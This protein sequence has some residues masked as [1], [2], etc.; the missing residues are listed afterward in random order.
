MAKLLEQINNT[1]RK[2][3][4]IKDLGHVVTGKTPS[5]NNPEDWGDEIDFITPTDFSGDGKYLSQ[6]KRKISTEGKSRYRN[7]II[8]PKSVVVTCIGSDMGKVV[9]SQET[10]LTNQQIN[11]II[12]DENSF[13]VD[14]AYYVLKAMYSTLRSIAEEG[15]ST[16]PIIT[17][18]VFEKIDFEAPDLPTQ[19]KI[20]SILSAY[21]EKI[22]NNNK[23][24]KNLET[25]AQT[26][27]NEW[28]V[29]FKFPGYEKV[30]FIDS[31]MGEIPEGWSVLKLGDIFN[32]KY[33]KNLPTSKISTKGKFPVYGAGGV[34]G[35]YDER[36]VDEKVILVT[37]RGNGSGTIWRTNGEG[38]V[39]NNSFLILARDKFH[40][41]NFV[42][43]YFLLKNSNITSALSGSA[44]PQIT[45]DGLSPI[46]TIVPD[47]KL[48]ESFQKVTTLMFDHI[49]KLLEENISLKS[50][51]DQLLA[52]LI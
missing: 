33:G 48:I 23:I 34:I 40:Y 8:P 4:F 52:K 10:A 18:S 7:M 49:D 3:Y 46:E 26:I 27:F 15:G 16:M 1:E 25:T 11:S 43:I 19:K 42:F 28:F 36:N 21:D 38:F 39:T 13:D 45:I 51:R 24:I 50:L 6:V 5:K 32:I 35:F 31:E 22:E 17:K 9:V 30:K 12:V 47:K 41:I 37:C 29:N 20:A 2:T 14:F 44:Q